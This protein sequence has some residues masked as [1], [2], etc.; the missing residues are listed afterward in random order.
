MSTV[1]NLRNP[2]VAYSYSLNLNS[3]CLTGQQLPGAAPSSPGGRAGEVRIPGSLPFPLSPSPPLFPGSSPL[4][5]DP[6]L[7]YQP[8]NTRS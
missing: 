8:Y 4:L 3:D 2:A 6:Y 7:G 5:A 1:P